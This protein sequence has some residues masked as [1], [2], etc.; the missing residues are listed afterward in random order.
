MAASGW[1]ITQARSRSKRYATR[2]SASSRAVSEPEARSRLNK[3]LRWTVAN[4]V[5]VLTPQLYVGNVKL[6]DEDVD[7]GLE[8]ALRILIERHAKVLHHGAHAGLVLIARSEHLNHSAH[9]HSRS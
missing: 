3:S 1:A 2:S 9:G 8:Y 6:C 5:R 7:L 4:N